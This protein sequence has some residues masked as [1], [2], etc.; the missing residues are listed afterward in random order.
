MLGT[1][2]LQSKGKN[3]DKKQGDTLD[4]LSR[5][6]ECKNTMYVVPTMYI[7]VICKIFIL[8]IRI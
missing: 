6:C 8:C 5:T 7:E 4:I 3:R 1:Q 2:T